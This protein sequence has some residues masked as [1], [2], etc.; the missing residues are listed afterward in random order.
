VTR[1]RRTRPTHPKVQALVLMAAVL[2]AVI[3][4]ALISTFASG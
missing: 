2:L 3:A 4:L 1:R